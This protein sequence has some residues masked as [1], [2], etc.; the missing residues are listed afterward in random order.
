MGD[1]SVHFVSQTIDHRLYQY[2]GGKADGQA[3]APE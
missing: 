1:G 3:A 2:L